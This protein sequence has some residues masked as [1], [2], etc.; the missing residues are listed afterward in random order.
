MGHGLEH[1]RQSKGSSTEGWD[2]WS[3]RPGPPCCLLLAAPLS[4]PFVTVLH[5][6]PALG[7]SLRREQCLG[8]CAHCNPEWPSPMER[9]H[10]GPGVA[11]GE[12]GARREGGGVQCRKQGG[13]GS[14]QEWSGDKQVVGSGREGG[15]GREREGPEKCHNHPECARQGVTSVRSSWPAALGPWATRLLF[16]RCQPSQNGEPGASGLCSHVDGAVS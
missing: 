9:R 14:E 15:N 16:A 4:L 11:K 7:S 1:A 2:G 10:A 6:L 12:P 13:E 3:C 5:L 8:N